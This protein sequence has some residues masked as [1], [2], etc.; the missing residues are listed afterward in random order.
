MEIWA[1]KRQGYSN[2][3]IA[4]KL[5]IHR[6]TVTQYLQRNEFPKYPVVKR[7]SGLEPYHRM[8]EDWLSHEEY[9][10]TRV[11]ELVVQQGYGGSDETVKRHVR[12]VKEQRDRVA[13]LRCETLPGQPSPGGL[14]GLPNRLGQWGRADPVCLAA[15]AGVFPADVHGVR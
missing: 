9:Q 6:K 13:Y 11:H 7:K 12:E 14:R 15:G 3:A 2:R 5:G 10:A 8:I 4:R 1:L